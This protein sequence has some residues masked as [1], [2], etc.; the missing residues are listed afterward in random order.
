MLL[1]RS[2]VA[3]STSVGIQPWVCTFTAGVAW[4]TMTIGDAMQ[5]DGVGPS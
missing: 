1:S 2:T 3:N 4:L 5:I